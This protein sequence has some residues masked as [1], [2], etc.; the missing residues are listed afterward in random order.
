MHWAGDVALWIPQIKLK[1]YY[2]R[3]KLRAKLQSIE[4]TDVYT[5]GRVKNNTIFAKQ[6]LSWQALVLNFLLSARGEHVR[7]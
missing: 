4:T 7:R 5:T 1:F 3:A 2:I 6:F